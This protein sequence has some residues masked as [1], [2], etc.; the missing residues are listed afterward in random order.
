MRVSQC[1]CFELCAGFKHP[2]V[3]HIRSSY[4]FFL[5]RCR[6][7]VIIE[8]KSPGSSSMQLMNDKRYIEG[9]TKSICSWVFYAAPTSYMDSYEPH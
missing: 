5:I 7:R 6:R 1:N 3:L 8:K 4:V 9:E 2:V